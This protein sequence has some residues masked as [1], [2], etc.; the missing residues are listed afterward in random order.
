MD[1]QIR[2]FAQ[3]ERFINDHPKDADAIT[4]EWQNFSRKHPEV[5]GMQSRE[6]FY[7]WAQKNNINPNIWSGREIYNAYFYL[8]ERHEE[9][10]MRN[11]GAVDISIVPQSLTNATGLAAMFLQR[12]KIMQDDRDYQNIEDELKKDWLKKNPSKDFTSKEGLDYLHG[13]LDN[14]NAPSLKID[15]EKAF[16]DNPKYQKRVERYDKEKSKI[17]KRIDNDPAVAR[18]KTEIAEHIKA[19]GGDPDSIIQN[20]SWQRFVAEN[21]GKAKA[22]AQTNADIKRANE[23]QKSSPSANA[24]QLTQQLEM[25]SKAESGIRPQYPSGSSQSEGIVNRG[26]SRIGNFGG[27]YG[28]ARRRIAGRAGSLARNLSA[29]AGRTLGKLAFQVGTKLVA[30]PW[31]LLIVGVIVAIVVIVIIII[32]LFGGPKP[33]PVLEG[34]LDENGNTIV[35]D[36]NQ[37]AANL[38]SFYSKEENIQVTAGCVD[39]CTNFTDLSCNRNASNACDFPFPACGAGANNQVFC[40]E[41][42]PPSTDGL[43]RQHD[44][45]TG[46]PGYIGTPLGVNSCGSTSAGPTP[47]P[48]AGCP[49]PT[50]VP[51]PTP[52]CP[53][54]TT[55][56]TITVAQVSSL[57]TTT[58]ETSSNKG[59]RCGA[60]QPFTNSIP[61]AGDI[62]ISHN[63]VVASSSCFAWTDTTREAIVS[64]AGFNIPK[65]SETK[66]AVLSSPTSGTC[67]AA[68]I[69]GRAGDSETFQ[70][71]DTRFGSGTMQL[72]DKIKACQSRNPVF[73]TKVQC[74]NSGIPSGSADVKNII[75]KIVA[76]QDTASVGFKITPE[77]S[78]W[79]CFSNDQA[80]TLFSG[81]FTI[82]TSGAA[83][84]E[85]TYCASDSP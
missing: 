63:R 77:N 50:S 42:D 11:D 12:P 58:T 82:N 25:Q 39:K 6:E 53:S 44:C 19:R 83:K 3:I 70:P 14:D 79:L 43:L 36:G 26:T 35:T 67:E 37:C 66:S 7:A 85:I 64:F 28:R 54:G 20:R 31:G 23:N 55:E 65:G 59:K 21:P 2:S 76:G 34:C 71:A 81:N 24:R 17:Y 9:T 1:P 73:P 84:L 10:Q 69:S 51:S 38:A 15:A 16:R 45:L 68:F 74:G 72:L 56:K 80:F 62:P 47:T 27:R 8:R 41:Y 52:P 49:A 33:V 18:V 32:I 40:I 61:Q 57:A 4:L 22:Y 48:C 78:D 13:S 5:S 30:N 60:G 75:S 46:G 29:R